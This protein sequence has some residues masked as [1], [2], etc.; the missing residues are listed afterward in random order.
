M[1][2]EQNSTIERAL[3]PV[4]LQGLSEIRE[5]FLTTNAPYLRSIFDMVGFVDKAVTTK[6]YYVPPACIGCEMVPPVREGNPAL[7]EQKEK[8][9][10]LIKNVYQ[11][12][13]SEYLQSLSVNQL[14]FLMEKFGGTVPCRADNEI[15][16]FDKY[17]INAAK[18]VIQFNREMHEHGAGYLLINIDLSGIQ[19][20]IYTIS[21]QGALKNLRTRSFFIELL[22]NHSTERILQA[23]NL[24]QA[25][26]FLNGGGN[27]SI[28]SG[29]PRDYEKL[30]DE[31]DYKLNSRLLKDFNGRLHVTIAAVEAPDDQALSNASD[32]LGRVSEES[33]KRKNRKFGTLIQNGEFPFISDTEPASQRCD[34]CHKDHDLK[35]EYEEGS[36]DAARCSFCE[37]LVRLG[38]S[39]PKVK[40]IY[41][42]EQDGKQCIRIEDTYYLLADQKRNLP[43]PWVVFDESDHF[44]EDVSHSTAVFAGMPVV[45]NATLP[46]RVRKNIADQK[47]VIEVRLTETQDP[48]E[49]RKLE[50]ERNALRDESPAMLEHLAESSQG[51][52]FIGALRMDADNMG[53]LLQKSF[54]GKTAI[55]RISSFSRNINYFFKLYL[56]SICAREDSAERK[57]RLIHLIYA[58]GDD[59]FALGAWNDIADL[60]LIIGDSFQQYTCGNIDLGLSAG[61]SIHKPKFP[62]SKMAAS[63]LN[64]L[65][66]S[67]DNLQPCWFC[68]KDWAGCPL[69]WNGSC[70]RKDSLTPFFSEQKAALKQNLDRENRRKY[71]PEPSRLKLSFKRRLFADNSSES[72][73]EANDFITKPFRIFTAKDVPQPG[74]GFLHGVLKTLEV[75][76]ADGIFYLPRIVWLLQKQKEHLIKSVPPGEAGPTRYDLYDQ[77]LHYAGPAMLSALHIP[78]WWAILLMKEG[79]SENGM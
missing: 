31:I 67:K 50:D 4:M 44:L 6:H 11:G 48:E 76:Y 73:D 14:Y 7:Q 60:S 64:A 18:A 62:V 26:V 52:K 28:L 34:I 33:F 1:M 54:Y 21:S 42:A 10:R 12:F 65:N 13:D 71:S 55:E 39:I 37:R 69:F 72:R 68:R 53:K 75:W 40:Y 30:L 49:K 74:R 66:C 24:H 45:T 22:C 57:N 2:T 56:D 27:I 20:F 35:R 25:N 3:K 59:L 79:E 5:W 16:V 32:L 15:S 58:G 46:T 78:V 47:A 63:S 23:F 77:N 9:L 51:A 17:R 41:K 19:R 38:S 29:K 43:C 36:R 70:R 61:F 8:S